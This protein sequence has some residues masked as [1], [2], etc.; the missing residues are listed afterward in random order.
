MPNYKEYYE[1][2]WFQPARGDEPASIPLGTLGQVPFGIDLLFEAPG[3]VRVGIEICEDLWVPIP[4][5]SHQALAGANILLNLSAS[6]ETIGKASYRTQLV[7]GHSGRCV[8][9]CAYA[10]AGP[11]ESTTDL[12]F[13]GHCLIAENGQLLAESERVGD[14]RLRPGSSHHIT[15]DVDVQ[16]LLHDRRFTTSFHA[17]ARNGP[18][19]RRVDFSL[20]VAPPSLRRHV[21]GQPF[22]PSESHELDRRCAEIFGIQCA[23]LA[24]RLEQLPASMPLNIGISG[25]LDSTLAL[26]V[27]VKTCDLLEREQKHGPRPHNA[28]L[29]HHFT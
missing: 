19:Y 23:G 29:R 22:V 10:S 1:A 16:K 8:A 6:N 24:K 2:R 28:R 12:V 21:D 7:T 25:G 11:S 13:S 14:G 17:G 4:P 3:D 15:C 20:G 5:S 27:A 26:L 9:A 18:A